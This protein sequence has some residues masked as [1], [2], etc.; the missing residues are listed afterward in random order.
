MLVTRDAQ[1]HQTGEVEAAAQVLRCL[2]S[3]AF[4]VRIRKGK[5][6]PV[7]VGTGLAELIGAVGAARFAEGWLE[8]WIHPEDAAASLPDFASL[9]AET[10]LVCHLR[11]RQA[12][13][14]YRWLQQRCKRFGVG[15]VDNFQIAGLLTLG[16]CSYAAQVEQQQQEALVRLATD[17]HW[18]QDVHFRYVKVSPEFEAAT[19]LP[20][21]SILGKTR[22]EI[23]PERDDSGIDWESHRRGLETHMS[24]RNF[25]FLGRHAGSQSDPHGRHPTG[26]RESGQARFDNEGRFQ[27][28][29]GVTMLV[30][31]QKRATSAGQVDVTI[32]R[33]VLDRLQWAVM[34]L[35]DKLDSIYQNEK[36]EEIFGLPY[37]Y[38]ENGTPVREII[39][40]IA[41]KGGY[42]KDGA[43]ARAES[44]IEEIEAFNAHSIELQ[45][46]GGGKVILSGSPVL[47]QNAPTGFILIQSE[48]A[49]RYE[50]SDR[51]SGHLSQLPNSVAETIKEAAD[52][53]N[54]EEP[55]RRTPEGSDYRKYV[56]MARQIERHFSAIFY[57]AP[58]AM[59]MVEM[60][61][62]HPVL[63][64][65]DVWLTQFGLSRSEAV[66]GGG[67]AFPF[68]KLDTDREKLV[69]VV[70]RHMNFSG[71]E[72]E[73]ARADSTVVRWCRC[74]G[75]FFSR[76]D[77]SYLI[78]LFEDITDQRQAADAMKEFNSRLERS[79]SDRTDA[80]QRAL[81]DLGTVIENLHETQD[82]LVRS[83]KLAAL[84]AM[85]AGVAHELNT[86]I[87][88]SLMVATHLSQTS[89]NMIEA[90]KTGLRRSMLDEYVADN[91]VT[92]GVLVR[93]L[94]KAA[95]LVSS[96]KQVAVDRTSSKRRSFNLAAMVA[97]TVTTLG[98]SLRKTPY[99]V[100][101]A[102]NKEI[103]LD[104]FPGPLGQV[105]TNLINNGIIHAFDGLPTGAIRVEA[106]M[107]PTP[108]A[109]A[110]RNSTT[111]PDQ[112]V[113]R[114]KDNG[115]GIPPDVL[116]QIF[117]PFF[118][119]KRGSGGSG[120][121]LHI[122][123]NMVTRILSGSITVDSEL[124]KGSCF[125]LILPL[126][127]AAQNDSAQEAGAT[128]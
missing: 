128:D 94:G 44:H 23:G 107:L 38:P 113:V 88:N 47:V 25:E 102:V 105:L 51:R 100:E 33:S 110:D 93:N 72:M 127:A 98:P 82:E 114:V 120:L 3:V 41:A 76:N 89:N 59:T 119:T 43:S 112:I 36:F 75:R 115:A 53:R 125:T 11:V 20:V 2:A 99:T 116:P 48:P 91:A 97:E 32:L 55:D 7:F 79:V 69:K 26:L 1:G 27:G 22:W 58:L 40:A 62:G 29:V 78:V 87:G 126:T 67:L 111:P 123:H 39:H 96:F 46:T 86:P 45:L 109:D 84:G 19:G 117:D 31:D 90:I 54:T 103:V 8:P 49:E 42:G 52:R 65:S 24:F 15:T 121:G 92:A 95:E 80:L 21:S 28:Y 118:T 101:Q 6:E 74:S 16:D 104:S 50:Q 81:N 35:D 122:V 108:I 13:G 64:V 34:V 61:P 71:G 124:G 56:E 12:N 83:K 85:V 4:L 66:G 63:L 70:A 10:E 68:L 30:G 37:G 5:L 106:E 18:E 77:K 17:W 14:S 73:Y 60:A 57:Q 9:R